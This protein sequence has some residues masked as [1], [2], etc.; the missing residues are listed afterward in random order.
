MVNCYTNMSLKTVFFFV[1]TVFS[2]QILLAE[3]QIT[4]Q[5]RTFIPRSSVEGRDEFKLLKDDSNSGVH[6]RYQCPA[7][8]KKEGVAVCA[9]FCIMDSSCYS[10]PSSVVFFPL[11][12]NKKNSPDDLECY[13]NLQAELNNNFLDL[14]NA[15]FHVPDGFYTN[16]YLSQFSTTVDN[17]YF[18]DSNPLYF[19]DDTVTTQEVFSMDLGQNFR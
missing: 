3:I 8:C 2:V 10:L 7:V 18:P 5:K 14:S 6:L 1:C 13:N 17:I 19:G 15:P 16:Q 12:S 9:I 4:S 11:K